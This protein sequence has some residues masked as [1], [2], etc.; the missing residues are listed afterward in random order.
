LLRGDVEFVLCF[1][2]DEDDG[3]DVEEVEEVGRRWYRGG[4]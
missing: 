2:V 4:W 1:R 3:D